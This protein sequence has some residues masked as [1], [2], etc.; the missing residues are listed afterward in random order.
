[1]D[2]RY[3]RMAMGTTKDRMMIHKNKLLTVPRLSKVVLPA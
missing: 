1:M 3:I 2:R